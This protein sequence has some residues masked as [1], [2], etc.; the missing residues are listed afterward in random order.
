MINIRKAT[1]EDV[2]D[3][4][5]LAREFS[6]EAPKSHKWNKDKTE[7]FILSSILN[8]VSDVLVLEEDGEVK[9]ALVCAVH[10]MYMSATVLATE[11]AWFV[12]KDYRGKKGSLLLLNSFEEWAKNNNADYITLCDIESIASLEKLYVRRGYKRTES[13]YM[14]EV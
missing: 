5:V 12:S 11:L 8:S 9:G 4:L 2:F 7:Q 10:E 13:T 1:E 6:R 3:I 14:K